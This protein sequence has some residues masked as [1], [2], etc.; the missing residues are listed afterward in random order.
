M[1]TRLPF[2]LRGALSLALVLLPIR[3]G[4]AQERDTLPV[5]DPVS[6]ETTHTGTFNGERV[7]YRAVVADIQ[8]KRDDGSPYV[9]LFTTSYLRDGVD[10]LDAR[11]V[12]FVFN[13]GLGSSSVWLHM[14]LF[15]PKRVV[16]PSDA[17]HAGN[18]PFT[19]AE[20]G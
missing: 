14:G 19:L 13:G 17:E 16:V 9:S 15:G 10:D 1:S 5:P 2:H 4:S 18:A 6:F 7:S 3:P 11:P 20:L 8:L 12:T